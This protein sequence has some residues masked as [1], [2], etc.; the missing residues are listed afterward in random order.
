MGINCCNHE[1]EPPEI[2][3]QSPEKNIFIDNKSPNASQ[4]QNNSSLVNSAQNIQTQSFRSPSPNY[5]QQNVI[6]HTQYQSTNSSRSPSPKIK[7]QKV[8]Y[9]NIKLPKIFN[10]IYIHKIWYIKLKIRIKFRAKNKS[11]EI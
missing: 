11:Q 4:T 2:T 10:Q 8:E 3:I 5:S 9:N 6:Y 7:Y 1:K